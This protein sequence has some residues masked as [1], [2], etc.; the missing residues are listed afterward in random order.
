MLNK[1]N[2]P[3][4][5]YY[6]RL[7]RIRI[8]SIN[9]KTKPQNSRNSKNFLKKR[10]GGVGSLGTVALVYGSIDDVGNSMYLPCV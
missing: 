9:D 8:S 1:V 4:F 7:C 3:H 2:I 6:A 5:I 10:G